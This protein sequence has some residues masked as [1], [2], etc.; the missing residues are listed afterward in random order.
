LNDLAARLRHAA[1]PVLGYIVGGK[2]KLDLRTIFP[3]QDE[4][5]VRVLRTAI[6]APYEKLS[7]A[8]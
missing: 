5:L 1:P 2:F 4:E 8:F 7:T 3:R 6:P